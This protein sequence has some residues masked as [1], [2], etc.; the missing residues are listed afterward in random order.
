MLTDTDT[1]ANS[2]PNC[3]IS[4]ILYK[5]NKAGNHKKIE[6]YETMF[7]ELRDGQCLDVDSK[8]AN[9]QLKLS[10][11]VIQKKESFLD[12]VFGGCELCL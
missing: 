6:Y 11:V 3:K 5:Y 2:D 1:L 10:N 4:A 9:S 8:N 7:G 12:Y